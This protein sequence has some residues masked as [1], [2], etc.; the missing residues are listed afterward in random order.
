MGVSVW[1]VSLDRDP[2]PGQRPTPPGQRP[3]TETPFTETSLDRDPPCR[4]NMGPDWTETQ[5]EHGTRDRDPLGGT[6]DQSA[7]QEVTSYRDPPPCGQTDTCKNITLPQTSFAGG[8]KYNI[9]YN[10]QVIHPVIVSILLIISLW[11]ESKCRVGNSFNLAFLMAQN[12]ESFLKEEKIMMF[13][14]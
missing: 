5:K 9:K 4:R 11:S 8:N 3:Q 2:S 1:M 13:S 14:I 6:W 7:R 12:W 10:I